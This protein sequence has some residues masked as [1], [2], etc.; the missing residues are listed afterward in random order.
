MSQVVDIVREPERARS[1]LEATRQELLRHL[2]QPQSAAGLARALDLP[3][4]RVNYHLRELE[5]Q[6]LVELVE[7]KRRGS[8]TERIYRRTGESYALSSAV[9]GSLAVTP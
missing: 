1:L 3:R 8:V 9:L 7:E 2:A 4:Q 5:S 6:Q